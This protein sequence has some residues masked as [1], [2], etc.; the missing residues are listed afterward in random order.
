MRD[1]SPAEAAAVTCGFGCEAGGPCWIEAGRFD[2]S[3]EE[4]AATYRRCGGKAR[5]LWPRAGGV[6]DQDAGTVAMFE[7]IDLEVGA[8]E[9]RAGA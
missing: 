2:V 7:V 5:K 8:A 3:V 4:I 9:A 1:R 6:E